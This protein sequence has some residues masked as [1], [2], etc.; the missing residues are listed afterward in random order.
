MHRQHLMTLLARYAAKWPD[1]LALVDRFLTFANDHEHCLL[2]TCGPGHIT[3]SAWI[4]SPTGDAALLTHH[5][6][7]GRWLQLGGHVDGESQIEQACLRE[8]QEESGMQAFTFVP[9]F[10]GELVPIDLDV[11]EIPARKNEPLHEHWDVRFLLR[12]DAGQTLVMSDESNQLQ[13]APVGSLAEFTGEESVLRLHRKA[14]E[15]Q[16]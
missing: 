15:V 14:I 13:W 7:L 9:W 1:E 5:K 11:H 2:R 16:Q 6:K 8:A 10:E 3:S 12:A 4:L